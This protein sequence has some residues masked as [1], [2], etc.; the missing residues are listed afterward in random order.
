MLWEI[1]GVV[2]NC[3]GTDYQWLSMAWETIDLAWEL[4]MMVINGMGNY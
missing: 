1:I 3:V 4:I 2:I